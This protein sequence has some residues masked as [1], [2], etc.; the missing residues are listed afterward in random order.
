VAAVQ[1]AQLNVARLR[2][3]LDSPTLAPFV[4]ALDAVNAVADGWPGFV[5]RLQD[6]AGNATALRP[7]GDDVIVNLSVWASV[8]ALRSY[9]YA[10]DHAGVLRRRREWFVPYE[11]PHLVLWWVPAGHR[12]DLAEAGARLATLAADGPGP[13]AFTLREPQPVPA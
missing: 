2:E 11:G 12:P 5:W 10:A 6:D 4:A 8:E 13:D 7:W 1:L 3:P 9:V